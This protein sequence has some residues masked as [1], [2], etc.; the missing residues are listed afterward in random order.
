MRAKQITVYFLGKN[1]CYAILKI[2][3][4][5]GKFHEDT[6]KIWYGVRILTS[7]Q[8]WIEGSG[9]HWGWVWG[10]SG[11]NQFLNMPQRPFPSLTLKALT[12]IQLSLQKIQKCPNLM[13]LFFWSVLS[14]SMLSYDT[15]TPCRFSLSF[16]PFTRIPHVWIWRW[17]N[18]PKW[19]DCHRKLCGK[20][21]IWCDFFHQ[22]I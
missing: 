16:P 10:Y 17:S 15:W 2:I 7:I 9:S 5:R 11:F 6:R 19:G 13:R 12:S 20:W 14:F 8:G 4:P 18:T 21:L 3:F 1:V 22:E